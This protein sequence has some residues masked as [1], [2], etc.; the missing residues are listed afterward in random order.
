MNA[1]GNQAPHVDLPDALGPGPGEQGVLLDER[2]SVVD[3]GLMGPFD[4]RRHRRI[5][6]RPQGRDRLHRRER[7]VIASNRLC[8]RPGVFRDLS[9]QL[10]RVDRLS[11]ML[12]Q[13]ELPGHLGPHPRPICSRH[14]R[15]GRKASC[16]LD[17]RDAFRHLEPERAD[18]TIDD[19]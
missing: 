15:V 14:R 9:R 17:R 8:P 11:A 3:R 10:P 18:V 19:L 4:H 5:S 16:R 2:Q 12:G 13:E 6:D 7:Q 1:V